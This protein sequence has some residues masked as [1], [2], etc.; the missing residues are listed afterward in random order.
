MGLS[1]GSK[2]IESDTGESVGRQPHRSGRKVWGIVRGMAIRVI[3]R[4]EL[5]RAMARAGD[6]TL[7]DVT[8]LADGRVLDTQAKVDTYTDELIRR[9]D[10]T[11]KGG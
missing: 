8:V 1:V 7:D 4:E 11:A 2:P 10:K 5:R 3:P 9:A 6:P